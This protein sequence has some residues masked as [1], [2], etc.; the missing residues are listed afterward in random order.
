[1]RHFYKVVDASG[2]DVMGAVEAESK[3]GNR[4]I[5]EQG[6]TPIS[7]GKQGF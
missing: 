2:K 4:K 7:I 3:E 5:K 1:M 6:F